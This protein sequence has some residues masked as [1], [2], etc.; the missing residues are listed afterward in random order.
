MDRLRGR[1]QGL[2]DDEYRWTPAAGVATIE[3]RVTHIADTLGEERNWRW[4]GRGPL[5]VGPVDVVDGD[6]DDPPTAAKGLARLEAAYAAWVELVGSLDTEA[7]FRPL[8]PIAGPYRDELVVSFVM[9]I[10]DELVHHAAEV[11]L[12]RDL[13]RARH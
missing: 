6:A 1:V 3:W 5:P 10:F 7:V 12:M 4:L 8:G 2:T 11:G 9:H 13:Y